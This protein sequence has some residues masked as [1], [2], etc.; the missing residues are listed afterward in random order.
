MSEKKAQKNI[1]YPEVK[2]KDVFAVF[3]RGIRPNKWLLFVLIVSVVL[4]IVTS[5][6]IPLF[7]KQFFDI[8]SSGKEASVIGN[9]LFLII[10]YVLGFN[11][12]MWVFFR[13][14]TFANNKYEPTVMATLKQQSYDYLIQHSYAFFTSSFAGSL[15]QKVN[16]LSRAFERLTDDL[17]WNLLPLLVRIVSIL[18]VLFFVNKWLALLIF[19]W[20]AVFLTFNITFSRWKLKYDIK[21][22]EIDSKATGYLADTISNQNNVQ[23]FNG[24]G[25]ES[26]GY[27]IITDSQ[28]KIT[29][30]AWNLDAV[31]E[32][33][34]G[35]LGFVIEFLLF[36]FA[37]KYWQ[38]GVITIGVFVLLQ[39]YV[40]NIIMQLWGFT[41][42]VRDVY[43]S[44]ADAKEMVEIRLL[45]HEIKDK[46]DANEL[47]ASKG[48]I[49][50]KDLVFNFNETRKVLD[51][52]NFKITAGEK[53]AL[54][55]PSGAGKTTFV[56]LLLR[57]YSPT[58]GKI[59][60]DEQDI[61][62]ATQESLRKNISMVPQDP[63]LFHRTLAENI[64]YGRR[65]AGLDEIK[66]A[67]EM[68]HCDEFIKDLPFGLETYVGE[69]GIKLSGGERQRVAIAR[70]IL[71]NA[72][73]L[74]LDEATSSLDSHSEML[75]QDALN[76]LMKDKT[77]IVIAH[78]LSTIQKMD[79]IIV[80]DH[81][82]I[83]EQGSHSE[84]LKNENSLYKKL[85][86]LQAGGF[87]RQ[88]DDEPASAESF[89]EAKEDGEDE[90]G[91]GHNEAKMANF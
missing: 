40:I 52:V 49:E 54:V 67:A 85:W 90:E 80:V 1:I 79:R 23:L 87:L 82:K 68:A 73:I 28:A 4:A 57:L 71:K 47:P 9:Q 16:R 35:F 24:F 43:Q 76:N 55:G 41:R 45:P 20:T 88:E 51:N 62:N 15:V 10:F 81:G 83:I 78:R 61:S 74:I 77:T 34:Q 14:A 70:A 59:L 17:V 60:I 6:I 75:I 33:G 64:A 66:K 30:F 18:V 5:T 89:G 19:C 72:P 32:A 58:A 42:L 48:E 38:E 22:S 65:D 31:I 13:I 8:I 2:L 36:Y 39:A 27:K 29:N 37:I 84:L 11:G 56:R 53:V 86:E 63:I 12:L 3:W 91:E 7:Y 46:I 44:Y 21:A 25:F 69:R 26:R 50:F